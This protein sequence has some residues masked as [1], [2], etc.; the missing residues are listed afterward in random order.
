MFIGT[1]IAAISKNPKTA[2][3]IS[4]A[5][6]LV[7]Y[8]LSI[9]IDMNSK[10]E[11]LKYFTPFKYYEAKNLMYGGGFQWSFVILSIVIIQQ[12]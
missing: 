12:W 9:I 3:S 10:L 7:T 1:A 2:T 8:I 5:V 11:N 6:L 4:T